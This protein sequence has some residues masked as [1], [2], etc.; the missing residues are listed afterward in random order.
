M[1]TGKP[2][3]WDKRHTRMVKFC[4]VKWKSMTAEKKLFKSNM[5]CGGQYNANIDCS[6]GVFKGPC[7]KVFDP[8]YESNQVLLSQQECLYIDRPWHV[9]MIPGLCMSN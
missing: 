9:A 7:P 3:V 5:I 1:K 2:V 8:I 4:M 6:V